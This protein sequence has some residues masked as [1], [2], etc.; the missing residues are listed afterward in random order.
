MAVLSLRDVTFSFGGR[1]LI[2][3]ANLEI[4][5][6][7]RVALV[8]RNGTGKSTLMRLMLGELL[9][10]S[11]SVERAAG[12]KIARQI[13]DVPTNVIGTVFDEAANGFGKTGPAI[14]AHFRLHQGENRLPFWTKDICKKCMTF[15]K[16][17][18]GTFY[19]TP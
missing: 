17:R 2:E 6:G 10:D 4:E 5:P 18:L 9:P 14:A 7:E 3:S 1:P 15:P 8:G 16:V 12:T 13:Q 11:G 19:F